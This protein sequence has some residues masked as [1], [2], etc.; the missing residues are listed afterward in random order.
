[1]SKLSR[2]SVALLTKAN[3]IV[4]IRGRSDIGLL[5]IQ[6]TGVCLIINAGTLMSKRG[7]SLVSLKTI[8]L[9]EGFTVQER[10]ILLTVAQVLTVTK[11]KEACFALEK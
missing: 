7:D 3:S 4:A 6:A 11:S 8:T 10:I 5:S 9:L 2:S 1:M